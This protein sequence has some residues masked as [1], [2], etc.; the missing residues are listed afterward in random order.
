MRVAAA[1]REALRAEAGPGLRVEIADPLRSG[2][3]PQASLVLRGYGPLVRR[4][5]TAWGPLFVAFSRPM[6]GAVLER[7]LLSGLRTAMVRRARRSQPRVVVNLHPLLGPG[8]QAA[9][10]AAGAPLITLVTDLTLVHPGWLSPRGVHLLTPSEEA[11]SSCLGQGVPPELVETTGLPL[12]PRLERPLPRPALRLG[13]GLDPELPCLLV[14]GGA[15]GAGRV[16]RVLLE[17]EESRV[18]CQVALLCGRN[19]R[20][21]RWATG[22]SW[23]MPV[24]AYAFLEDPGSLILSAD[25][26]LGKAGPTAIGEA[27]SAG[28]GMV[29]TSA[30]RGQEQANLDWAV[31]RGMALA[32]V[33]PGEVARILPE[34]LG[35]DGSPLE[36]LRLAARREMP[37]GA[38]LRAAR[39]ILDLGGI[40]P[41]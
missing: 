33:H 5:P 29:L 36:R 2:A 38:A 25:L 9:A 21:L 3:L 13:L 6:A 17:V 41:R 26:Y 15:E 12:D 19:G 18:P 14:S 39:R 23:R 22:R 7:F 40:S 30:L 35:G 8:A 11:A 1:L 27:V 31:G 20:L 34:L 4:A 32:A 16:E 28:L 10:R 37:P 24:H